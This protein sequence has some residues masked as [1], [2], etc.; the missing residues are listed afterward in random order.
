MVHRPLKLFPHV[1]FMTLLLHQSVKVTAFCHSWDTFRILTTASWRQSRRRRTY[2]VTAKCAKAAFARAAV[3]AVFIGSEMFSVF[4]FSSALTQVH[5]SS[6]VGI[7]KQ[8]SVLLERHG[9]AVAA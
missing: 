1:G 6:T 4:F 8:T 5:V 2:A 7:P 3:A 9:P